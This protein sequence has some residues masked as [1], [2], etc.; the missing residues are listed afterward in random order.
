MRKKDI[1]KDLREKY[2]L[3]AACAKEVYDYFFDTIAAKLKENGKVALPG[4]GTLKVVQ[5]SERKG[6]NPI[7][8]EEITIP[9]RKALKFTAASAIKKAIN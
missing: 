2:G 6:R 5:R 4:I 1:V 8:G 9:A 7:T 3:T